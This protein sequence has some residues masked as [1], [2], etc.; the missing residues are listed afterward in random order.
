MVKNYLFVDTYDKTESVFIYVY[1][2]TKEDC[3]NRINKHFCDIMLNGI[4][5][6]WL[7]DN[8]YYVFEFVGTESDWSDIKTNIIDNLIDNEVDDD[9]EPVLETL[10]DKTKFD[11]IYKSKP[12][13]KYDHKL[14]SFT[15]IFGNVVKF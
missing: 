8:D 2:G 9:T 4:D 14:N 12:T 13:A 5:N 10:F 15:D 6:Y 7:I 3:L 1:S 11:C